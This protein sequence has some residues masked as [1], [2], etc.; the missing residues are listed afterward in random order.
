MIKSLLLLGALFA[1]LALNADMTLEAGPYQVVLSEKE[2]FSITQIFFDGYEIGTKTG[3]YGT[4]L[5]TA[6]NMFIGSGHNEGGEEKLQSLSIC[7]DGKIVTERSGNLRG[8]EIV[9][10]KITQLDNLLVMIKTIINRDGIRIDKQWK[11]LAEQ[12]IASFYIFQYCWNAETDVWMLGRPDGSIGE[13]IFKSD[14]GWHLRNEREILWHAIYSTKAQ[15]GVISYF[16]KYFPK[17]GRYMSWDRSNYHKFYFWAANPPVVPAGYQSPEYS[18]V[19]KGFGASENWRDQVKGIAA[20]LTD[21]YPL[22]APP[23]EVSFATDHDEGIVLEGNGKF[24]AHKIPLVLATDSRFDFSFE[25][26][27]SPEGCSEKSH[28]NFLLFG[29]HDQDRKFHVFGSGGGDIPRD[30]QWHE[31]RGS[32]ST[33]ATLHDFNIY[34]YNSNSQGTVS[35]RNIRIKKQ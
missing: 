8:E 23:E 29:Q 6:K 17:Q 10:D 27:K 18:I 1:A 31:I 5:A 34:I 13:G 21:G 28:D 19:L 32:F 35:V 14:D 7:V 30:G 4:I 25:F 11:A 9:F 2:H 12:K 20:E 16:S 33:P 26:R 3:F 24:F 22:P 15:K